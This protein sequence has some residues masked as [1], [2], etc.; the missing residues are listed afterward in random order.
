MLS[1]EMTSTF[2]VQNVS[3]SPLT[4]FGQER[5]IHADKILADRLYACDGGFYPRCW[6][7]GLWG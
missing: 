1:E 4:F 3:F 7:T 5:K 6:K 2:F